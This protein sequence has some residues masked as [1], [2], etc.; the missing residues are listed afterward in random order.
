MGF[1]MAGSIEITN[2]LTYGTFSVLNDPGIHQALT[3][4]LMDIWPD[5]NQ[6]VGYEILEKLPYLVG[7]KLDQSEML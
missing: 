5:L 1:I 7:H 2:A 6:A 4:E 3:K